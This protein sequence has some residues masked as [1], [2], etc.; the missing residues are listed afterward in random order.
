MKRITKN[1]KK[2]F[3][4]VLATS[5]AISPVNIFAASNDI[6]GHWAEK[7]IT[8]WQEKGLISGYQ[9]GTFKPNKPATRAEFARILNQALGLREKGNVAFSDVSVSDWFYNDVSVALG[10]KYTAGFPDGTFKPND[11]ITRAQAAVFIAKAVEV[12]GGS[13]GIFTDSYDIPGWAKD[14]IG[15]IVAKGYMSGYP[16][17][18]FKPNTVLT[19]AEAVSTLNRIMGTVDG[20]EIIT[21]EKDVIIEKDDTK[22]ENR[23]IEGDVI[24]SE[25]VKDGKVYFDNV[26][27]R[28]N[29]IIQ[30]GGDDSIYLEDTVVDGK[31][32]V[33]KK[34]VRLRLSGKTMLPKVE[35]KKVCILSG[36]SFSGKVNTI[37]IT[38]AISDKI[39]I[40][41]AAD[42]LYIEEKANLFIT[43]DIENVIIE[44]NGAGTKVEVDKD[45]KVSIL[46]ADG[47]VALSGSGKISKLE[48]NV[49]N[50]TYTSDLIISKTE[51]AKGV[52][53]PTKV[54]PSSGGSSSNSSSKKRMA[55]VKTAA[56]FEAAVA[57][58]DISS[59][60]VIG[61]IDGTINAT[62]SGSRDL[63][64]NFGTYSLGNVS[65]TAPEAT[66]ITLNDSGVAAAGASMERLTIHAPK[67][68]VENSVEVIVEV[69]IKAVSSSTFKVKDT[70]P[71]VIMEGHGRLEVVPTLGDKPEVVI[72]T[73]QSVQLA[74]SIHYV[75]VD[76]VGANVVVA[77]SATV[78][79]V[80]VPQTSTGATITAASH[81]EITQLQTG[82]NVIIAGGGTISE[83]QV[84]TDQNVTITA[85]NA[86]IASITNIG[87]GTVTV[88]PPIPV[89]KKAK[90]PTNLLGVAPK[91]STSNDGKITGVSSNMEYRLSTQTTYTN[92]TGTEIT[93][94]ASGIYFVRVKAV[95]EVLAS[96]DVKV[97]VPTVVAAVTNIR[98][99]LTEN[100]TMIEVLFNEPSDITGIEAFM[101]EF[102]KDGGNTWENPYENPVRS[103]IYCDVAHL[104]RS[105]DAT[106]IYTHV[107]V[108]SIAKQGYSDSEVIQAIPY[109]FTV[110][111]IA[112]AFTVE[113]EAHGVYSIILADQPALDAIY[114]LDIT[115]DGSTPDGY[116]LGYAIHSSLFTD[117]VHTIDSSQDAD[118][119]IV[120]GSAFVLRMI[121]PY[122]TTG[123]TVTNKSDKVC[124]TSTA[125]QS[126]A[127][128]AASTVE[129]TENIQFTLNITGAKGVD[130]VNLTGDIN[131]K[132]TSG[133][134]TEGTWG[135]V[136]DTTISFTDGVATVPV[137]LIK[138]GAQVLTVEIT[139]VTA[140]K[141]V[142]VVVQ[143]ATVPTVP[144][145][146]VS[147]LAFT[148]TDTDANQIGGTV[149]WTTPDET[150]VK[151]YMIYA[152]ADG[153]TKGASLGEVSIRTTQFPIPENTAYV[154][155]I[156]IVANNATGEA[157]AANYATVAVTDVKTTTIEAATVLS[158]KTVSA[159]EIELTM[160]TALTGTTAD[161]RAFKVIGAAA[162][163]TV[164]AVNISGTT[165]TLT[166]NSAIASGETI[167]LSYTKTGT[168]DLTNGTLVENFT[169]QVVEN[170][171][172]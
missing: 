108:T 158:A 17:G 155:Y 20:E 47:K 62:R 107:K 22:L 149:T 121:K 163:P 130:G 31:M 152:S 90:P 86:N 171:V 81:G 49:D 146:K 110:E 75:F 56:E 66:A 104:T 38:E 2:A 32:I 5:M 36:S 165:V 96:D 39:T 102:S 128:V 98:Y 8:E 170:K 69:V 64:I 124:S 74:G 139:G 167:T 61:D 168:G 37:S 40:G 6:H 41:V 143:A 132:V 97:I 122:S 85:P 29:L 79:Q 140:S 19:R 119:V 42:R 126:M 35:M 25:K 77:G 18:T 15:A 127:T 1:K 117:R 50:I 144:E 33:E 34:D 11:T 51:T 3:S 147:D 157:E 54:A 131:V 48:A 91:T 16:D 43:K 106:T 100:D 82:S 114:V 154:S 101:V 159:T 135:V 92:I 138:T 53:A 103:D 55:S 68:H 116:P 52:D 142:N 164:S 166:L 172:I 169:D 129:P 125:D 137:T 95:G 14:S 65:I 57:N 78:E 162:N 112:P 44:K 113:K 105:L 30:G 13:V 148:D 88:T 115:K 12:T 45:A 27:I 59:I 111:G 94:L 10:E 73:T 28:G 109:T 133:D 99:E 60:N 153:T 83:V 24:I 150:N 156:I 9:D 71:S 76:I 7:T 70:V 93:D 118:G 4:I 151:Q 84:T 161:S 89:K 145:V 120:D 58:N 134:T 160:S 80:V 136:H 63:S 21:T 141:T 46:T 123:L 67:A 72:R 23:T 26:A 87:T